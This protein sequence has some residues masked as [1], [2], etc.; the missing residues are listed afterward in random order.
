MDLI[1]FRPTGELW[2]EFNQTYPQRQEERLEFYRQKLIF[3][4]LINIR[5][6]LVLTARGEI[7]ELQKFVSKE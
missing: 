5:Q 3:E 2:K 7:T 1:K 4:M 6:M